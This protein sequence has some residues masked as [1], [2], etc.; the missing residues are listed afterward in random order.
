MAI[1]R[2][3][4]SYSG[5]LSVGVNFVVSQSWSGE[6]RLLVAFLRVPVSPCVVCR[7]QSHRNSLK[8]TM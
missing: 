7:D 3:V 6:S 5:F 2:G 8:P 4:T 1:F